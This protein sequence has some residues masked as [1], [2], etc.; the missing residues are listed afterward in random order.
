MLH[1]PTN[2]FDQKTFYA[3]DQVG[4]KQF[5][6]IKEM[7]QSTMLRAA[8]KTLKGDT[9][10]ISRLEQC[11]KEFLPLHLAFSGSLT[12]S[13][14][15]TQ[16]FAYYL[17]EALDGEGWCN[18]IK[19]ISTALVSEAR[20]WEKTPKRLQHTIAQ[21]I[22]EHDT[23]SAEQPGM[24]VV[25]SH[26]FRY[27]HGDVALTFGLRAKQVNSEVGPFYN[28]ASAKHDLVIAAV[29]LCSENQATNGAEPLVLKA[30]TLRIDKDFQLGWQQGAPERD[31]KYLEAVLV[32]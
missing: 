13:W 2:T 7:A 15:D 14:W 12:P 29:E 1:L 31:R 24:Q 25:F 30:P 32:G 6:S 3:L 21:T 26:P 9:G 11:A 22:R 5:V 8:Y 4:A 27:K 28:G 20:D 23:Y 16:P 18:N 10:T 17:K 19:G